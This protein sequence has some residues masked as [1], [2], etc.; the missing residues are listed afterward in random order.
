MFFCP[1]LRSANFWKMQKDIFFKSFKGNFVPTYVTWLEFVNEHA[2]SLTIHATPTTQSR[3]SDWPHVNKTN[4]NYYEPFQR[5]K[6]VHRH[7]FSQITWL[8]CNQILLL[9]YSRIEWSFTSHHLYFF[10]PTLKSC[11]V[12]YSLKMSTSTAVHI[13]STYLRIMTNAH[14]ILH[15][16]LQMQCHQTYMNLW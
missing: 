12:C 13:L 3:N 2:L 4:Q 14:V 7:T 1:Y 10:W 15:Y 6:L 5:F 16:I 9:W 11:L 8:I